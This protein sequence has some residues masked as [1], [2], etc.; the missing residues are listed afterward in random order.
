MDDTCDDTL[1]KCT[2]IND[3]SKRFNRFERESDSDKINRLQQLLRDKE[4]IIERLITSK[5]HFRKH[6]R[7]SVGTFEKEDWEC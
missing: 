3:D 1:L 5:K 7:K 6:V 4:I 2:L